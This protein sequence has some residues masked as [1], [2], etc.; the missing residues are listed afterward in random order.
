MAAPLALVLAGCVSFNAPN[1][2]VEERS[3]VATDS[4]LRVQEL[5]VGDGEPVETGDV[6]T[7][8]YTMWLADGA[9]VDSTQDRGTPLIATVGDAPL[10]GLDEGLV[11][12]RP[13]GRRRLELTP[14][15]AYGAQGVP[16]LVPPDT[17]LVLEVHVL[18]VQR[19]P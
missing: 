19:G 17:A 10:A 13:G 18:E 9:R 8:D 1:V 12:M 15:L 6:V 14:D 7:F 2:E 16:G 11:G 3:T 5:F 4:G